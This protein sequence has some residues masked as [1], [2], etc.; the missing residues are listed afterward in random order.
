MIPWINDIARIWAEYFLPVLIQNTAFLCLI[1]GVLQ[2]FRKISPRIKFLICLLAIVKLLL[3]PFLTLP[4][5]SAQP[6]LFS[7]AELNPGSISLPFSS[8]VTNG[9]ESLTTPD[10]A[11]LLFLFWLTGTLCFLLHAA[12]TTRRLNRILS[13]SR[14]IRH[15][16]NVPILS[17]PGISVPMTVGLFNPKVFVPESWENWTLDSRELILRHELAHIVRRDGLT[18]LLQILVQSLYFFH[19]L[20][21][22]I[23]DKMD[24]YREMACDDLTTR[25]QRPDSIKFA[26]A[27]IK[28]A[29]SLTPNQLDCPSASALIRRKN[30]LLSRI[31]Y[32][33]EDKPMHTSAIRKS[34]ILIFLIASTL[35]LSW[36]A[37]NSPVPKLNAGESAVLIRVEANR[38]YQI[39][40]QPTAYRDLKARLREKMKTTE[41]KIVIN[42]QA[43]PKIMMPELLAVETVLRDLELL[44]IVYQG[45]IRYT[46]APLPHHGVAT[47]FTKKIPDKHL[48]K[49][50]LQQHGE[51]ILD[52]ELTSLAAVSE[53]VRVRF[54]NNPKVVVAIQ[55]HMDTSYKNYVDLLREIKK[56]GVQ[57]MAV[58]STLM[59]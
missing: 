32:Q 48:C 27:L 4:V 58:N 14:P 8:G 7:A 16:T 29:E 13:N 37:G 34:V 19:P 28:I 45:Q 53:K 24:Q 52:N 1:W 55:P 23:S 10:P 50:L 51:I 2:L 22:K 42:I 11:A 56:S 47:P 49:I 21:W 18:R 36:K 33:M 20:V 44:Q 46:L 54:E 5:R 59:L 15:F 38:Q 17:S 26:R 3:P 43:D 6:F 40:G 35:I 30:E 12:I 9:T 57:R 31:R 39:D 41:E 25:S